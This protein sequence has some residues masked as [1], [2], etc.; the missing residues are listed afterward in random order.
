MLLYFL[1]MFSEGVMEESIDFYVY[2]PMKTPIRWQ[3]TPLSAII[4]LLENIG[5][6]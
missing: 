2:I 6:D 5:G 4:K 1:W 3:M